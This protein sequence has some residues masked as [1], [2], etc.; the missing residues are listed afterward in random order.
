MAK[1]LKDRLFKIKPVTHIEKVKGTGEFEG[2]ELGVKV[3]T[4]GAREDYESSMFTLEEKPDGGIKAV[5]VRKDSKL[6]LIIYTVCDP[7]TGELIFN[8]GDLPQLR[9]YSGLAIQGL[10]DAASK[11]NDLGRAEKEDAGSKN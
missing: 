2:I 11:A 6:K 10:F 4:A 3:M 9:E 7:E 8:E 5:P 1:A